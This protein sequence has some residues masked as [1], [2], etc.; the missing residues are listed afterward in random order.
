MKALA[1]L[2]AIA[3]LFGCA[4][5]AQ[6][7]QGVHRGYVQGEAAK[8][9][10]CANNRRAGEV[11]CTACWVVAG[12]PQFKEVTCDD[13]RVRDY[14]PCATEAVCK[15]PAPPSGSDAKASL[16]VYDID[17]PDRGCNLPGK[18]ARAVMLLNRD[19]VRSIVATI[20]SDQSAA[21]AV[22]VPP[23]QQVP[24]GCAEEAEQPTNWRVEKAEWGAS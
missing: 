9:R 24:L 10:N 18:G 15:A 1:V 3:L 17:A 12:E 14:G 2:S 20:R 11:W 6:V 4:P 19:K 8:G 7:T 5:P 16:V 23:A 13:G 21:Q 22:T